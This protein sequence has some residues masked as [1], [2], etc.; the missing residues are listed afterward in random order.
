ME[1]RDIGGLRDGIGEK[2]HRQALVG[3][4]PH[5]NLGLHGGVTGETC[6]GDQIHIVKGQG[7]ERREGGLHA[8]GGLGGVDAHGEV[9]QHDVDDI[10]PDLAGVIGVVGQ[11]LIVGDE[12]VD[13]VEAAGILK[14]HP[15][16]QGAHI[17]AQMQAAGGTVAGKNDVFHGVPSANLR[18]LYDVRILYHRCGSFSNR[19]IG[20]WGVASPSM[21]VLTWGQGGVLYGTKN[22]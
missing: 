2:A 19:K 17:V 9:V 15:A 18:L 4:A 3:K 8:D 12:D 10:L 22:S 16:L 14:L 21:G 6:R 13:L 1:G 20:G 7:M 5:L 11:G